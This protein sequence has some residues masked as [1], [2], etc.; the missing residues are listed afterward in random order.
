MK[1][2]QLS[3]PGFEEVWQAEDPSIHFKAFI[4]IHSTQ[5]GPAIGGVRFWK[6]HSEQEALDDAKSLAKIMTYKSA[7]MDFPYGGGKGVMMVPAGKFERNALYAAFA[8]FINHLQGRFIGAK[9]AGTTE[10]DV[11]EMKRHSEW[12]VGVPKSAGGAGDPSPITARGVVVGIQTAVR[13]AMRVESLTGLRV[14][15]QGLGAVGACVAQLLNEV[16]CQLWGTDVNPRNLMSAAQQQ[17][18]HMLLPEEALMQETDV[19]VP[20]ALGKILN[21][22]TIPTLNAKV[23]AGSA[24]D[25]L[26]D[27]VADAQR[28][29]ERRILYAP[30]FVINGGGLIHVVAELAGYDQA[31]VDQKIKAI[32]AILTNIFERARVENKTTYQT[33]L[34]LAQEKLS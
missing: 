32:G 2:Q 29:H 1:F 12:L 22:D 28:L 6:Y 18:L 4:A 11:A 5:R 13:E 33:A 19:L 34:E 3:Q 17:G 24:N 8:E 10:D 30:D 26:A 27:P 25:Q 14:V 7:V 20:C 23:I 21:A 31:W 16:G 15:I 9:D